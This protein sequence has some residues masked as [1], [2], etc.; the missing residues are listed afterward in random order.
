MWSIYQA[1]AEVAA[2]A[3]TGRADEHRYG[4]TFRALAALAGSRG[5]TLAA[6]ARSDHGASWRHRE[7]Y[8]HAKLCIVDGAWMTLGSANLVDLS[9]HRDHSE[10]N[11][12]VWGRDTCLPVLRRLVAEHIDAPTDGLDDIAA[13]EM[14]ARVARASRNSLLGGGPVLSGCYALDAARYGQDP[15]LTTRVGPARSSER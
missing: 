12:S 6:L 8:S 5:F 15:P 7:I 11:A 1:S 9:L 10:L 2:L 4:P 14:L 13:V 3:C